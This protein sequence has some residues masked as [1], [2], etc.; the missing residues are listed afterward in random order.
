MGASVNI[1]YLKPSLVQCEAYFRFSTLFLC[2][3]S[4]VCVLCICVLPMTSSNPRIYTRAIWVTSGSSYATEPQ[5][6]L[7]ASFTYNNIQSHSP[8]PNTHTQTIHGMLN[9]I[10]VRARLNRGVRV[11]LFVC[12]W[13]EERGQGTPQKNMSSS[14]SMMSRVF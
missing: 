3:Q 12:R 10:S 8:L 14:L 6:C 2:L 5:R 4:C 13:A 9:S 11:C 7:P 1:S